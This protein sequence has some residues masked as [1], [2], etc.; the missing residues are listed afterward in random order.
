MS[1]VVETPAAL[2]DGLIATAMSR[3]EIAERVMERGELV[4][5][6]QAFTDE[7]VTGVRTAVADWGRQV[8]AAE[9]DDFTGNYHRRRVHVARIQQA[10]HVFHDYNFNDLAAVPD[11][12]QRTLRGFFEPL[13]ELYNA[14]TANEV[15][16]EIPASGPYVHPQLIHYPSGGGFFA[17]HWHNLEPQKLGFIVSMAKRG[18][19][20]RNGGTCFEIDGD[21]VDTEAHQEI[22]DILVWRYDHPHW[23]TQSDLKDKFD[24]TSDAGRWVAT[25]AYFDPKG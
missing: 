11:E 12:L 10:P 17:R 6:K 7:T 23:V 24:W 4:I 25:F 9:L 14:L 8:A 21:V 13:R 3:D 20:F 16:F 19:D 2:R 18:R 22:G 1:R 5:L 15:R